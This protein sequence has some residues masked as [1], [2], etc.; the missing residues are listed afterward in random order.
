MGKWW[1]WPNTTRGKF[2]HRRSGKKK[3]V[4]V[5]RFEYALKRKSIAR[6]IAKM[7]DKVDL[8]QEGLAQVT[9]LSYSVIRFYERG[10]KIPSVKSAM[11]LAKVFGVRM[12][13]IYG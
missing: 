12:E 2:F 4:R 3:R 9:G 1:P 6:N 5:S 8:S 10:N 13:K 11:K 7:R